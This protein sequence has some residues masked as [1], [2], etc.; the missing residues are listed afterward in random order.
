ML[1]NQWVSESARCSHFNDEYL[2]GSTSL[3]VVRNELPLNLPSLTVLEVEADFKDLTEV[4][5]V[6]RI[7]PSSA[8]HLLLMGSTAEFLN[9]ILLF[10][11]N[12]HLQNLKNLV[13]LELL[14]STPWP[15]CDE[16]SQVDGHIVLDVF[17][18]CPNL[19]SIKFSTVHISES[20]I[21]Q[22]LEKSVIVTQQEAIYSTLVT[23]TLPII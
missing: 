15:F 2:E 3:G 21:C 9:D 19:T 8:K 13:V 10:I 4:S 18:T 5:G 16:M 22:L 11:S 17:S 14:D 6:L 1:G 23:K 7:V 20:S 12:E